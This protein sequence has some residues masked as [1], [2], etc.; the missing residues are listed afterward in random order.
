MILM[1]EPAENLYDLWRNTTDQLIHGPFDQIQGAC[2]FSFNN[3][4]W[5]K[6]LDFDLDLRKVGLLDPKGRWTR[7]LNQ[8]VN[9]EDLERFLDKAMHLDA[10]KSPRTT[11]LQINTVM[12]SL[13]ED[14]ESNAELFT[15]PTRGHNW[16]PCLL[17]ATFRA[18]YRDQ[19]PTLAL[20]SRTSRYPNTAA[21]DLMFA[22]VLG[23]SVCDVS[24]LS[25]E[26]L[27]FRWYG[28]SFFVSTPWVVPYLVENGELEKFRKMARKGDY[29]GEYTGKKK[30]KQYYSE[31][32]AHYKLITRFLQRMDRPAE[33]IV[34]EVLKYGQALRAAKSLKRLLGEE[35]ERE[36]VTKFKPEHF[37]F[38]SIG[39][40]IT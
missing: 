8:Y 28:D 24:N 30:S 12:A 38:T 22:H 37:D 29:S 26:E 25:F 27:E 7:F 16:G 35:P 9:A 18:R 10:D 14:E 4:L 17:A 39:I 34:P 5:S 1:N 3:I 36:N 31:L 13:E 11:N 6:T 2:I 15:R 40:E 33:F 21:L 20:Y 32:P 19:P 23:R